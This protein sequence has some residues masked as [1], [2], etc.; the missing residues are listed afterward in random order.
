MPLQDGDGAARRSERHLDN[1]DVEE[2]WIKAVAA[3][4]SADRGAGPGLTG[5]FRAV[6]TAAGRLGR[7]RVAVRAVHPVGC[8]RCTRLRYCFAGRRL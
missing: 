5:S 7:L 4:P 3:L 1:P 6:E 8:R 2:L